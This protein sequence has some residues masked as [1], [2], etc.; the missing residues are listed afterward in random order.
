V[1]ALIGWHWPHHVPT[2]QREL[3]FERTHNILVWPNGSPRVSRWAMALLILLLAIALGDLL[4]SYFYLRLEHEVWPTDSI[5]PPNLMLAAFSTLL[6]IVCAGAMRWAHSR[7]QRGDGGGLRIGLA[8]AFVA[9]VMA[10]GTLAYD[11]SQLPYDHT[12]NA[13]TSIFYLLGGYL[14][15]LLLVGLGQNLFAQYLA[16]RGRYSAREHVAVDLNAWYWLAAAVLWLIAAGTIYLAPYV[17]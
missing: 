8:V 4:F 14:A 3:D 11:F 1:I 7:I 13:Y 15:L 17:V 9:G 6:V 5:E 12:L 10:L 16:W 2:T